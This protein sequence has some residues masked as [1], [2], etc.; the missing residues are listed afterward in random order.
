MNNPRLRTADKTPAPYKL[1]DLPSHV[2]LSIAKSI[3][4]S[5][6]VRATSAFEGTD[7]ERAFAKAIQADWKA[8]NVGL[9]DVQL[10]S[11][12]WGAKTVKNNSPK[13]CKYVR[14]ISG[15]NSPTFSY[16]V[17]N[18]REIE[19]QKL[20]GMVLDIWNHRVSSVRQR[21][22]HVR[23]VVLVKGKELHDGCIFEF[24][25]LREEPEKYIWTW[26]KDKNLVGHDLE[27][28]H[29]FTW[30]PSGSQFTIKHRIE[31]RHYFQL[32]VPEG[33]APL[34]SDDVLASMGYKDSWVTIKRVK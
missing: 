20:G 1:N 22:A 26:N 33:I 28:N 2:V 21:F 27:G 6:H 23:T 13:T 10:G 29:V 15:R 19:P 12:C 4:V 17:S 8:S 14:L 3:I 9:D 7:W 31:D 11:C 34:N 18:I 24:E 5:R 30:Q 16:D 25:T 32:S